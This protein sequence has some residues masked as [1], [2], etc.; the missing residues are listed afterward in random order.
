MDGYKRK[1]VDTREKGID[2]RRKGICAGDKLLSTRDMGKGARKKEIGAWEKEI[3]VT[4][5]KIKGNRYCTRE[6]VQERMSLLS[7]WV[8]LILVGLVEGGVV[9]GGGGG[10]RVYTQRNLQKSSRVHFYSSMAVKQ[11]HVRVLLFFWNGIGPPFFIY[12]PPL[13]HW[14]SRKVYISLRYSRVKYEYFDS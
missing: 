7:A 4:M 10:F 2:A 9:G 13:G 12:Q 3:E 6:K 8:S 1:G 5:G 14:L 11:K